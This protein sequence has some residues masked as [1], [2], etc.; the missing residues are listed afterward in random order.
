MTFL[1]ASIE[2]DVFEPEQLHPRDAVCELVSKYLDVV[3][4]ASAEPLFSIMPF[5]RF[6]AKAI[7]WEFGVALLPLI[8]IINAAIWIVRKSFR[9]PRIKYIPAW[10]FFWTV[11]AMKSLHCG[12]IPLMKFFLNRNLIRLFALW[13]A[14][15]RTRDLSTGVRLDY[16]D[17]V[18]HRDLMRTSQTASDWK[19]LEATASGL[20]EKAELKVLLFLLPA[21]ELVGKAA[22]LT[23]LVGDFSLSAILTRLFVAAG[24]TSGSAEIGLERVQEAH[25]LFQ[26][27]MMASYVLMLFISCF[28]RKRELFEQHGIYKS[29]RLVAT[30][31]NIL[32]SRELP[33]DLIGWLVVVMISWFPLWYRSKG[34]PGLAITFVLLYSS[35]LLYAL[36]RRFIAG[37]R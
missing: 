2:G 20:S 21:V 16:V 13:H 37:R 25:R 1:R 3:R 28:I 7:G 10:G 33:L 8:A 12:E 23:T 29:E 6:Y 14:R 32:I 17:A 9:S 4:A 36:A 5:L 18:V 24:W 27:T 26:I 11:R 15:S 31:T 22:H 30:E 19:L 34:D 35:P